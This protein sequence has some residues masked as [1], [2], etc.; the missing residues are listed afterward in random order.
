[1]NDYSIKNTTRAE[2]IELIKSFDISDYSEDTGLDIWEIYKDYID[3]KKEITECNSE[4]SKK[5]SFETE[6]TESE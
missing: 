2:R 5:I 3:G 1:M 4:I 6:E